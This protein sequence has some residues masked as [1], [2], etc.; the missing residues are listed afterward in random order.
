MQP[1]R[2]EF[3]IDMNL[4]PKLAV[5]LNEWFSVIAKSFSQLGFHS[6][7]DIDIF[8]K[9]SLQ[10]N[11]III[12]TKDI[13]FSELQKI[14][15]SPPKIM[16]LNIGNVTNEQLKQIIRQHFLEAFELLRQPEINLVEL[17]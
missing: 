7:N 5:W 17:T 16:Y 2:F 15:G 1:D 6:S 13:D 3:W 9:A 10:V 4:P 12:T 14:L 11:I 8:K